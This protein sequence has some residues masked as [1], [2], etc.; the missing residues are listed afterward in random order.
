[1]QQIGCL[2]SPR[3]RRFTYFGTLRLFQNSHCSIESRFSRYTFKKLLYTLFFSLFSKKNDI[4]ILGPKVSHFGYFGYCRKEYLTLRLSLF[5]CPLAKFD[6]LK[7]WILIL[8]G[9]PLTLQQVYMTF[10]HR[11]FPRQRKHKR[12]SRVSKRHKTHGGQRYP[13]DPF[14]NERI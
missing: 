13:I 10:A 11:C 7:E 2:K 4:E 14:Q 9:L 12:R 3:G 5:L 1:M 6:I 8:L